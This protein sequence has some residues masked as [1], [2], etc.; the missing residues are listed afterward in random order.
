ME[1]SEAGSHGGSP[2]DGPQSCFP[3]GAVKSLFSEMGGGVTERPEL[4]GEEV[5]QSCLFWQ[6]GEE[7]VVRG[8]Q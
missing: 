1:L 8:L 6:G 3:R 5:L 4:P 2:T 7:I